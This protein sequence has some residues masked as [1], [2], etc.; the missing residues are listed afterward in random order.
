MSF[1][2][3][4]EIDHHHH[5]HQNRTGD[6][7]DLMDN[8]GSTGIR[9]YDCVFCQRG[10]TTA[11][12]LGGHMN[13]HRKDRAN[14]TTNKSNTSPTKEPTHNNTIL[15]NKEMLLEEDDYQVDVANATRLFYS[16]SNSFLN[17][18]NNH[19]D[20]NNGVS[21]SFEGRVHRFLG[22][23]H[24]SSLRGGSPAHMLGKRVQDHGHSQEG[25]ELD[26]EL[27]LGHYS[28]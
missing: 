20:N 1:F 9:S 5:H 11:Q 17:S 2:N 23:D 27:R 13:I 7:H 15:S 16:S 24:N 12:A 18:Q 6:E 26:L 4:Q 22:S 14:P 21:S 28:W 25:E 10:F 19:H 3:L 8:G